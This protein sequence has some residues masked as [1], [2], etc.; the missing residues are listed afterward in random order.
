[1]TKYEELE[2]MKLEQAE[3]DRDIRIAEQK[4]FD[5]RFNTFFSDLDP[6]EG[7]FQDMQIYQQGKLEY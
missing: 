1:M 5:N 6:R 3:Q 4:R 7:I 2:I